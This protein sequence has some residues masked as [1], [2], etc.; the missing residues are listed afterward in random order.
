MPLGATDLA[1]IEAVLDVRAEPARVVADLRRRFP[2]LT[3]TRCDP[4]DL[5]FETPF[6]AGACFSLYLVDS[7][8][9]CWRLTSDAARATGLV[10]VANKVGA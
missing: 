7:S 4:S 3:V 6:R 2:V 10:V 8:D 9:H 5:D 1:E